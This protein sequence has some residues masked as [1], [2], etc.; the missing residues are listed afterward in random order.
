MV[1][2]KVPVKLSFWEVVDRWSQH[3]ATEA[4]GLC[5]L[6]EIGNDLPPSGLSGGVEYSE[7]LLSR[8]PTAA[9]P[10]RGE[11]SGDEQEEVTL[12]RHKGRGDS[13]WEEEEE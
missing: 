12:R 11:Q 7:Q 9:Q 3:S 8:S 1:P 13:E 6:R 4:V 2:L 5:D 10:C